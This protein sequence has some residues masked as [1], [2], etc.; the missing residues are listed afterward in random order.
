MP[1][2]VLYLR[3]GVVCLLA[4]IGV[5]SASAFEQRRN[6]QETAARLLAA[7]SN[8]DDLTEQ[9]ATAEAQAQLELFHA[10]SYAR[11]TFLEIAL[12][13]PPDA[14]RLKSREQAFEVSLSQV[15]SREAHAL[16]E[17]A[18]LR[19]VTSSTDPDILREGF[20]LMERCGIAGTLGS[21]ENEKLARTLVTAM[22]H[23]EDTDRIG[24]LAYGV[25][26]V[27]AFVRQPAA[28]DLASQLVSR[29]LEDTNASVNDARLP[30]LLAL[31]PRLSEGRAAALAAQLTDR[32][33]QE[34]N[35]NA[36]RTLAMESR[37][38]LQK[39]SAPAAEAMATSIV[40]RIAAEM[41]P[42]QLGPLQSLLQPVRDKIGSDKA[43]E[44]ALQ[45]EPRIVL[46]QSTAD[47]QSMMAAWR[48]LAGRVSGETAQPLAAML[49]QR[50]SM[51]ADALTLSRLASAVGALNAAPGVFSQAGEILI[52]RMR[53]TAN[54]DD[55]ARLGSAVAA[56]RKRLP[57]EM[58]EEAAGILVRR[59]IAESD[60]GAIGAMAG[61]LDDL[62][63]GVSAGKAA[64]FAN[65]LAKRMASESNAEALLNL[66]SGFLAVVERAG[67]DAAAGLAPPF[68]AR[69]RTE[70]RPAV[71]RTLAFCIGGFA[72]DLDPAQ[73]RDAAMKLVTAMTVETDPEALRSL[74]AG[75][76]AVG[77][78]T[79]KVGTE[80]FNKAASILA[81]Q[82]NLESDIAGLHEL[83]TS[84]HALQGRASP[85][86]FRAGRCE[87]RCQNRRRKGSRCG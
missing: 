82:I 51:P 75:L 3:A 5:W 32:I 23:T 48:T 42:G 35:G 33:A 47:L 83:A 30:A 74:T 26:E 78:K 63:E 67:N 59:M 65:S 54:G 70:N 39:M 31:E 7:F 84:L 27:A 76:L 85:S 36:M 61:T 14:R 71:L 87:P 4:G 29:S 10:S 37:E 79:D 22:L 80:N 50:M 66:A 57:G 56:L 15:K 6:G 60:A 53:T 45:I 46:E 1:R 81:A 49:I 28:D 77:G 38:L 40:A 17:Q 69:I 73:I 11:R 24:A 21:A 72:D 41:N 13:N 68:L 20:A 34:H 2:P 19:A 9:Q 16:F 58:T 62:D 18:I 64:E 55:L 44:L 25:S 43:R 86:T 12:S 52:A 8:Q